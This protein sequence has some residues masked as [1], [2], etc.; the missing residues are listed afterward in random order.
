[1]R[2]AL[3]QTCQR[4]IWHSSIAHW[5]GRKEAEVDSGVR[6]GL[7]TYAAERLKD[8]ENRELMPANE[9]LRKA[10]ADCCPDE[11]RPPLQ[12]LQ[13]K[14]RRLFEENFQFRSPTGRLRHRRLVQPFS[15]H[16]K[17]S[18]HSR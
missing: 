16:R 10:S 11:G 18:S 2:A 7:P 17:A 13:V 6:S 8:R 12:A 4:V 1:M 5:D 9:I 15:P 3:S 14:V